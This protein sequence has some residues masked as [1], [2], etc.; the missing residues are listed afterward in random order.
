M[1]MC[2]VRT[3]LYRHA[4]SAAAQ[5]QLRMDT[6]E[7]M[8]KAVAHFAASVHILHNDNHEGNIL[9]TVKDDKVFS[10]ELIDWGMP[11]TFSVSRRRDRGGSACLVFR[12]LEEVVNY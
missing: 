4:T 10:V 1:A 6:V 5:K 12:D 11:S 9:V 8:C 3:D 7:L 2:L